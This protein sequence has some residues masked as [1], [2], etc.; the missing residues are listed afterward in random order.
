[1]NGT[2]IAAQRAV[3]TERVAD[4]IRASGTRPGA[5]VVDWEELAREVFAFQCRAIPAYGRWCGTRGVEAT[6]VRTLA[7]IPAVPTQ[8]F[9]Q[10]RLFAG[11]DA[12][13]VRVFRTSGTSG[14]A[15]GEACFS[16][17]G[18]ALMDVAIEVRAGAMLFPDALGTRI[19]ALAP[20]PTAD[21]ERIMAYGIAHLIERFGSAG[22]EFC[23]GP[24]GLDV[25][26]V[27][28]ALAG[29]E[30]DAVPVT[31]AGASSALVAILDATAA[32][33]RP[34]RLPV[35]SRVMH[36]GGAKREGAP[37]DGSV[38]RA[39]VAELLGIPSDRCINLLGMTELASQHYDGMLAD[40][41]AG[42]GSRSR[43]KEPA[44]WARTWVVDPER[45]EPLPRGE[46][47]VLR[48]LDLA[49]VERPLCVQSDDVGV[50]FP[51]GRFEILGRA[52]GAEAR[53]CSLDLEDWRAAQAGS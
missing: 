33:G 49:N 48:H 27:A 6:S 46:I 31:L 43:G 13:V 11:D 5:P 19:L 7:D 25:G 29:A 12:D 41:L 24:A 52:A 51:D 20:S 10:L 34:F 42:D 45:G 23:V 15:R 18:L 28:A 9:K 32:R 38:V 16:R 4:A 17:E 26:R 40:S 44:P 3:L 1:M 21:P 36:A 2:S 22:S 53:G 14:A 39:R 8:A 37:I 30:A 47:G 50:A 35:G